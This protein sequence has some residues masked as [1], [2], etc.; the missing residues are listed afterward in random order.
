MK[1]LSL[2]KAL[3]SSLCS[4]LQALAPKVTGMLLELSPAQLLVM[5]TSEETLRQRV[6]EAVD[7][8]MSHNTRYVL[9]YKQSNL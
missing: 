4:Q 7:I 2:F 1:N 6:D 5:L 9:F 8:C 3:N